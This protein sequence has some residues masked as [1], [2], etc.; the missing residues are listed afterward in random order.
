MAEAELGRHCC[1]VVKDT[2]TIIHGRRV[3][4]QDVP[5]RGVDAHA[6]HGGIGGA[7][8]A[9]GVDELQSAGQVA[10]AAVGQGQL[11]LGD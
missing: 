8:R 3:G 9:G 4:E 5:V 2:Q 6:L 1:R 11:L 10:G 7:G